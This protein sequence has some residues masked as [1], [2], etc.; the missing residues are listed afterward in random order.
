MV[1]SAFGKLTKKKT[2]SEFFVFVFVLSVSHAIYAKYCVCE[3]GGPHILR[4]I[5]IAEVYLGIE[6]VLWGHQQW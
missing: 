1:L 2:N 3:S 4:N 5:Y 6:W